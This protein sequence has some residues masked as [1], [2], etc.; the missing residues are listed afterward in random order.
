MSTN[1]YIAI[2]NEDGTI[3]AAY[4]HWDGYLAFNGKILNQHYTSEVKVRELINKGGMSS[5]ANTIDE[6]DF[7]GEPAYTYTDFEECMDDVRNNTSVEF[8]YLMVKGTWSVVDV[9][10]NNGFV[11]ADVLAVNETG[12]IH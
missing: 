2:C 10:T 6:I 9:A 7:Y 3:E 5:L 8:V 12:T 4:C 11:L 1:S